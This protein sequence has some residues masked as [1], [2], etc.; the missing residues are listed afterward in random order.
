VVS[1]QDKLGKPYFQIAGLQIWVHGRESQ[2]ESGIAIKEDDWL[3]V[4]IHCGRDS[5]DVWVKNIAAMNL[6]YDIKTLISE[7]EKFNNEHKNK[8]V[9]KLTEPYLSIEFE[10]NPSQPKTNSMIEMR[11]QITPTQLFED[12]EYIFGVTEKDV[13]TL[14]SEL[15][16]LLVEYPIRGVY[17]LPG[18]ISANG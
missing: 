18:Q 15:K 8:V 7:L 6:Y 2:L 1:Y 5:S 17:R 11:I 16:K 10:A 4:T 3:I 14:L 12:H 9:Y 13:A